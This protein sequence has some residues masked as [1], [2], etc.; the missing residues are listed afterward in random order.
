MTLPRPVPRF[1]SN[2]FVNSKNIQESTR[3]N[4]ESYVK[5]HLP[6]DVTQVQVF[7]VVSSDT[8]SLN[9]ITMLTVLFTVSKNGKYR[10]LPWSQSL[11]R[12]FVWMDW[13]LWGSSE[14]RSRMSKMTLS[15]LILTLLVSLSPPLTSNTTLDPHLVEG[16]SP[17][18]GSRYDNWSS[19]REQRSSC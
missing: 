10:V 3:D 5:E 2:F 4:I 17:R 13:H 12:Q 7:R 18:C 14:S 15:A 6:P 19:C 11:C 8:E 1:I 16:P 9:F